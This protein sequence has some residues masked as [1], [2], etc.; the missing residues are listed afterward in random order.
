M[1]TSSPTTA[2]STP[3]GPLDLV[4]FGGA[5]DL[6]VRKLLPALYMAHLHHNLPEATRILA[7]GRQPWD[8]DTFTAFID[9]KVRGFIEPEALEDAAWTAFKERLGY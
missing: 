7:L 1:V 6:S 3:Q 4:I 8:R 2:T 9:D 5:G